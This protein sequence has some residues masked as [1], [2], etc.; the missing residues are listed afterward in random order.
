MS[1]ASLCTWNHCSFQ[2]PGPIAWLGPFFKT[3]TY[4]DPIGSPSY[5]ALSGYRSPSDTRY[6][7]TVW[8]IILSTQNPFLGRSTLP[9]PVFQEVLVLSYSALGMWPRPWDSPKPEKFIFQTKEIVQGLT[10]AQ[11]QVR[12]LPQFPC[13]RWRLFPPYG[14]I[15]CKGGLC[16]LPLWPSSLH[17]RVTLRNKSKRQL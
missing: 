8:Y 3:S 5:P 11:G 15:G 16:W 12:I 1:P 4:G 7:Y 13:G 2:P 14:I 6:L 17:I 9:F 10:P